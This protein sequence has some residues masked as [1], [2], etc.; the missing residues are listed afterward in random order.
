M[1]GA[2]AGLSAPREAPGYESFLGS[3]EAVFPVVEV[4]T[5][6]ASVGW[7]IAAASD[8]DPELAVDGAHGEPPEAAA[9]L[10]LCG[11]TPSGLSGMVLVTLPAAQALREA[12]ARATVDPIEL[13]ADAAAAGAEAIAQWARADD[14]ERRVAEAVA[15]AP[16]AR[17]AI[18]A[19]EERTRAVDAECAALRVRVAEL[20]AA[21]ATAS[22]VEQERTRERDE[23]RRESFTRAREARA[24]A[25]AQ[26]R[27]EQRMAELDT[28]A[29]SSV[30]DAEIAH[31]QA[32][33]AIADAEQARARAEGA[34]YEADAACRR[35]ELA[36]AELR[37]LL[38]DLAEGRDEAERLRAE[39]AR[40]RAAER[41]EG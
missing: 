12:A 29:R 22:S 8:P 15:E 20:E 7:V 24:W 40:A 6:S 38:E 34:R 25:D 18:L 39:L 1:L 2:L 36:E 33:R 35:T 17:E 13:R 16:R 31:D 27:V 41:A 32:A 14:A 11:D 5:Q 3:L 28:L 9:Y 19:A 37:R 30:H 23:A 10:A 21:L 4:A 26:G